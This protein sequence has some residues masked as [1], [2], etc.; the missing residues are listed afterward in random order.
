ME[1]FTAAKDAALAAMN[2]EN[3]AEASASFTHVIDHLPVE[4]DESAV[5]KC[6]CL[7]DRSQCSL[8]LGE[9]DAALADANAVISLYKELRPQTEAEIAQHADQLTNDPLIPILAHAYLHRGRVF[10]LQA[11]LLPALQEYALSSTLRLDEESQ[12]SMKRVLSHVGIPDIEQTDRD[13]RP[14]G[15]ILLHIL[16]EVN[17]IATIT[18][19]ME[20]LTATELPETLVK[21][22]IET[23]VGRVFIGLLQLYLDHEVIVVGCLTA[24]RMLAE[25]GVT[26]V[27]NGFPVLRIVLDHWKGNVPV[28]GTALRFISLSPMELWDHLARVDFVTPVCDSIDLEMTDEDFESAFYIL[29]QLASTPQILVQISAEGIADKIFEKRS[30]SAFMLLTKLTSLADFAQTVEAMGAIPWAFEALRSPDVNIVEGGLAVLANVF[31]AAS[32]IAVD[33]AVHAL[34]TIVPIVMGATKNAGIVANGFAVFSLVLGKAPEKV[35]QHRLVRA[36]SAILAVH[37]TQETACQNVIAFLYKCARVGLMAQLQEA[38]VAIPTV[39]KTSEA[40]PKNQ[41]IVERT[42]ALAVMSDHPQ[43]EVM[44]TAALEQ[45]PGSKRLLK[46]RGPPPA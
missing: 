26:D 2:A 5:L 31:V 38:R 46:L 16:N 7:L 41:A 25:K 20:Y 21:K 3:F 35:V 22:F 19:A 10:E 37:R 32:E 14:F 18:A 1:E 13:L 30:D 17:L 8:F 44:L 11:C 28:I 40:F 6:V 43:K 24:I 33:V 34:D 4:N 9:P 27:F 29:F 15:I 23:G 12:K 39:I 42:V 36:A 45:F